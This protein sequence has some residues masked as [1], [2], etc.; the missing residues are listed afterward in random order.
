VSATSERGRA[1]QLAATDPAKAMKIAE[2]IRD[3][4]YRCQAIAACAW[5]A[6]A[7]AERLRWVRHALAAA[8]ELDSPNRA[9]S[10]AAWPL[11][12]L[13]RDQDPQ[14]GGLIA[15]ALATIAQ[16]PNPV[17]RGDALVLLAHSVV[18]A[19]PDAYAPVIKALVET[20][21]V[22]NSWKV[23]RFLRSASLMLAESDI[24]GANEILAAMCEGR[25]SRQTRADIAAKKWLGPRSFF[26]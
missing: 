16:E 5:H 1:F 9:V 23:P 4:W 21:R 6:P 12:V 8:A 25:L 17:Q 15:E 3:P 7:R 2:N 13:A 22:A 18:P 24:N 10:V 14:L 19:G 11:Q 20:C 26:R